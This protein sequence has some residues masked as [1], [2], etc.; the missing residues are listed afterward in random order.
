MSREIRGSFEVLQ[1]MKLVNEIVKL[2]PAIS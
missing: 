2:L 1:M